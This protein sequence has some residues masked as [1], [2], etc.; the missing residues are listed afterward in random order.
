MSTGIDDIHDKCYKPSASVSGFNAGNKSL[1]SISQNLPPF[2]SSAIAA[3]SLTYVI[4]YNNGNMS[5]ESL[6]GNGTGPQGGQGPSQS[7]YSLGTLSIFTASY[8]NNMVGSSPSYG[9]PTMMFK[10]VPTGWADT[11]AEQYRDNV[12]KIVDTT[13]FQTSNIANTV[14]ERSGSTTMGLPINYAGTISGQSFGSTIKTSG[15]SSNYFYVD[16][17]CLNGDIIPAGSGSYK[18]P[19]NN[20]STYGNNCAVYAFWI[21]P[22]EEI[23]GTTVVWCSNM[24]QTN[25][26]NSS[27]NP[28]SGVEFAVNANLTMRIQRGDGTGTASTDRTT[29]TTRFALN[30]GQWNFVVLRMQQSGTTVSDFNNQIFV[31]KNAGRGFGWE[32]QGLIYNSGT[33]G[34]CKYMNNGVLVFSTGAGGNYWGGEIGHF[35]AFWE[36]LD[37]GTQLTESHRIQ[38]AYSTDSG[39]HQLYTS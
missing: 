10:F 37:N 13:N 4:A 12:Q 36:G 33:G 30:A 25:I 27:W 18:I 39:S 31:W 34:A 1:S 16:Y 24:P 35:Y 21:K 17:R 26:G 19:S 8:A 3:N 11:K 5:G 29:W 23:E 32:T 28:Y 9:F 15:A 2:T 14:P 6:T 38:M 7:N 22:P 20:T